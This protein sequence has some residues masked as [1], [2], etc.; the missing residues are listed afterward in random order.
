MRK[1]FDETYSR[2]KELGKGGYSVVF[3]VI[4]KASGARY[5]AKEIIKAGLKSE[6]EV[7]LRQEIEILRE[8]SHPHIIQFHDF[9]DEKA[10]FL[11][12]ELTF[13]LRLTSF[14]VGSLLCGAGAA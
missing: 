1:T 11:E 13:I 2:G 7:G 3:E 4:H 6:D 12:L 10:G 14:S 5:A 8:L 9:F